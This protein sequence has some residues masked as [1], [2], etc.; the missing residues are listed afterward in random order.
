M[1]LWPPAGASGK[2]SLPNRGEV[3]LNSMQEQEA[4]ARLNGCL[5]P[6]SEFKH[7]WP[8]ALDLIKR[9]VETVLTDHALALQ[10]E[11]TETLGITF[12]AYMFGCVGYFT[13]D[14]R[15]IEAITN[16]R[17]QGSLRLFLEVRQVPR[18]LRDKYRYWTRLSSSRLLSLP[19]RRHLHAGWSAVEAFP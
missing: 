13:S 5:P 18:G 8:W 12:A 19:R 17:F 16:S 11:F 7:H 14:P 1:V 6:Q 10:V 15:N 9:H 2:L 4:F 3:N